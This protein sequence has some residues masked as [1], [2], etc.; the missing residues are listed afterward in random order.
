MSF[1]KKVISQ[2]FGNNDKPEISNE[3]VIEE[4]IKRPMGEVAEFEVWKKSPAKDHAISFIVEQYALSGKDDEN[5]S[6]FRAL[7]TH[8]SNGFLL[9]R[10]EDISALEFQ[11]LFDYL[12]EQ[13]LQH[14]YLPYMSDRRVFNRKDFVE[15]I[16]RHYLKPSWKNN[17]PS[18]NKTGKM[19]QVFGNI[20]IELF[21]VN[22]EPTHL[23][24]LANHYSDH[25]YHEPKPFAKFMESL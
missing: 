22:D 19:F 13:T 11:H 3:P 2:V 16:E 10:I 12:K 20:S 24:L 25:K 1:F 17:T 14:A 21:K 5:V 9:R 8:S 6:L 18:T 7:R 4:T 15:T 23:K